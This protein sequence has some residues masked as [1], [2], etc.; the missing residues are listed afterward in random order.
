MATRGR[1]TFGAGVGDWELEYAC[2]QDALDEADPLQ[3]TRDAFDSHPPL[4]TGSGPVDDDVLGTLP[5]DLL[6]DLADTCD[7]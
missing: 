1:P 3:P 4:A 5:K 7:G 2:G 6:D